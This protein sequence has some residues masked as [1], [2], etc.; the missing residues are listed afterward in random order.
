MQRALDLLL[1]DLIFVLNDWSWWSLS[2]LLFLGFF[3]L[4]FLVLLLFLPLGHFLGILLIELLF[5]KDVLLFGSALLYQ[6]LFYILEVIS[7]QL[8]CA[9]LYR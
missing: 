1:T 4:V 8:D 3:D 6:K 5:R 9:Q 2:L 7:L